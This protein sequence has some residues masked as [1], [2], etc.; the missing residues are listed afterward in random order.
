MTWHDAT[1]RTW[2]DVTWHVHRHD[3]TWHDITWRDYHVKALIMCRMK[4]GDETDLA[5]RGWNECNSR[6]SEG[7][8]IRAVED[9]V[10]GS[11]SMVREGIRWHNEPEEITVKFRRL[12][13]GY[14]RWGENVFSVSLN[15]KG[16]SRG[17]YNKKDTHVVRQG[18]I[19]RTRG[20]RVGVVAGE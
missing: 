2:H 20:C 14:P 16:K 18:Y 7:R 12:I 6:K 17:S 4:C 5:E 19:E 15:E 10:V 1:F 11:R 3:V 8:I 9:K 13:L